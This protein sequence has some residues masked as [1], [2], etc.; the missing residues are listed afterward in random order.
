MDLSTLNTAKGATEGAE[1]TLRHPVT[2]DELDGKIRLKGGDSREYRAALHRTFQD[3]VKRGGRTYEETE[4]TT[5]S[6]LA[7]VTIDWGGIEENGEEVPFGYENAKRIYSEYPWI[8]EQVERFIAD[9]SNFL[10]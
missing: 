7:E 9:R 1:L 10:G 5:A 3:R 2:N 4:D 8:R 6:I